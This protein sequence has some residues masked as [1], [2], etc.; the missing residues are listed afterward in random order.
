MKQQQYLRLFIAQDAEK[1]NIYNYIIYDYNST[2]TI[3]CGIAGH[4]VLVSTDHRPGAAL[5]N[6][7]G[8]GGGFPL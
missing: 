2:Y 3:S 6:R 1:D 4:P 8:G 7:N 5:D